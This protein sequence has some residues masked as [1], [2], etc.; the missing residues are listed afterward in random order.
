MVIKIVS[1]APN[2]VFNTIGGL[3]FGGMVWYCQRTC[4]RKKRIEFQI[5]GLAHTTAERTTS[6]DGILYY[7][8]QWQI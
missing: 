7:E 3:K 1:L 6:L 2:D 8:H 4:M 5:G